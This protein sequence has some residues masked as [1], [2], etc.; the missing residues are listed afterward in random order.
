VGIVN[1]LKSL[2]CKDFTLKYLNHSIAIECGLRKVRSSS[3]TGRIASKKCRLDCQY[4]GVTDRLHL[5]SICECRI[6]VTENRFYAQTSRH[7]HPPQNPPLAR[8]K[9]LVVAAK[10][11]FT[12]AK[13]SRILSPSDKDIRSPLPNSTHTQH[14]PWH[15]LITIDLRRSFQYLRLLPLSINLHLFVLR[16]D[17]QSQSYAQPLILSHLFL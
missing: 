7:P 12:S 17:E 6:E 13:T 4:E 9:L 8:S 3:G 11:N 1:K 14:K 15:Y 2:P 10:I 5:F 16:I